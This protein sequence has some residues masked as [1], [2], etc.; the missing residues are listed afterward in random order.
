MN[1]TKRLF[2]NINI[3]DGLLL[4]LTKKKE[5]KIQMTNINASGVTT[6]D[7]TEIKKIKINK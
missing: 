4:R 1:E 6:T 5:K 2:E 3:I 7:L